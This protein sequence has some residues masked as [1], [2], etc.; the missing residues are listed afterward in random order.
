MVVSM[1][2]KFFAMRLDAARIVFGTIAYSGCEIRNKYTKLMYRLI[3]VCQTLYT[4]TMLNFL[5]LSIA[6]NRK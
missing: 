2:Y 4:Q 3:D 5:L 6:I 1:E